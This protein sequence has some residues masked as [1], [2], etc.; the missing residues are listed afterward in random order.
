MG[1]PYEE[2]E[3]AAN[4]GERLYPGEGLDGR[5]DAARHLALGALLSRTNDPQFA[6]KLGDARE[7]LDPRGREMDKFNKPIRVTLPLHAINQHLPVNNSSIAV[8][9]FETW[10]DMLR[11]DF[12]FMRPNR[13]IA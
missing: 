10:L 1:V 3:W 11:R 5:G 2:I 4:I 12:D 9:T 6:Q 13:D 8:I 7:I